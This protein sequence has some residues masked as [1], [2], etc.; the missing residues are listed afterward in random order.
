MIANDLPLLDLFMKL[1][2]V[3]FPLGIDEYRLLL[4]ALQ[5][6]FG[7]ANREALSRLCQTLWVKSVNDIRVFNVYFEQL[8]PESTVLQ[9]PAS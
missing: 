8:I 5:N 7:T 9:K 2:E 4:R 6:G 1:R 3:G